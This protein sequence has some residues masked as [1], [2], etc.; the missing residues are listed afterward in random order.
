M[1]RPFIPGTE[2]AP[3]NC[4]MQPTEVL[5]YVG[6]TEVPAGLGSLGGLQPLSPMLEPAGRPRSQSSRASNSNEKS[7]QGSWGMGPHEQS[8]VL[9]SPG[10]QPRVPPILHLSSSTQGQ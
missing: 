1:H 4:L 3:K 6:Q 8:C 2:R 9:P 5:S 7:P 10:E